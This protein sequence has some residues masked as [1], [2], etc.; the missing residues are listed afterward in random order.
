MRPVGG[1]LPPEPEKV[2]VLLGNT[3]DWSVFLDDED[4]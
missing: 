1:F 2:Q 3:P 4:L